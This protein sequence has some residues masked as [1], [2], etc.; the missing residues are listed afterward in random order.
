MTLAQTMTFFFDLPRQWEKILLTNFV[1]YRRGYNLVMDIGD[2]FLIFTY[3]TCHALHDT[4][5]LDFHS[6]VSHMKL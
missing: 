4:S 2:N 1:L 3:C 6:N 5:C